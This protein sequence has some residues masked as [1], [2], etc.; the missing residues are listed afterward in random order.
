LPE[1]SIVRLL[2]DHVLSDAVPE[3][4]ELALRHKAAESDNVTALAMEW[5]TAGERDGAE[6]VSTQGIQPGVFASTFQ[7][8]LPEMQVDDLDDA[9]IERSI[10]EINEA[11]R[12]GAARK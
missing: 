9:A 1:A 12:R 11:I 4:V 10:A 5:E 7:S 3:M 8:G 2:S 6:E